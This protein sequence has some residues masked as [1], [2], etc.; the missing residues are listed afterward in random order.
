M[1]PSF[2]SKGDP[3][4][5][6]S[7]GSLLCGPMLPGLLSDPAPMQMSSSLYSSDPP[8]ELSVLLTAHLLLGSLIPNTPRTG[9]NSWPREWGPLEY[10]T[11]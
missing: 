10:G 8:T 11:E 1:Q 3:A 2:G 4:L 5:S 9:T 7:C 6:V